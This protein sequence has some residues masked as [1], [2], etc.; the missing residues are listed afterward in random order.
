MVEVS[1]DNGWGPL[2][3]I[4]FLIH[5]WPDPMS[6]EIGID[7]LSGIDWIVVHKQNMNNVAILYVIP[8]T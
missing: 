1:S 5:S 2:I 8:L 4:G 3:S 7:I 6:W